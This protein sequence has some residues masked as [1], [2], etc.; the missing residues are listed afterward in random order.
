MTHWNNFSLQS[1]AGADAV[2]GC[3]R[4]GDGRALTWRPTQPGLL[5]IAHGRVWLTFDNAQQDESVRGGD[6][7]L[8]AGEA[9]Q[10]FP[11]QGLVMES[12]NA[13]KNSAVYFSWDLLPATAGLAITKTP[14]RM[15]SYW[16]QT[17]ISL[18]CIAPHPPGRA[19]GSAN[20]GSD[21]KNSCVMLPPWVNST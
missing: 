18:R 6:H 9:L 17:P 7:F 16:G 2:S 4:L 20:L 10:L 21:P 19:I 13:A 5:R 8:G 12:W 14:R 15:L 11:G 3:W 1:F